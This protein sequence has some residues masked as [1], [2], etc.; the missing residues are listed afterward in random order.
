M[1]EL[2][3]KRLFRRQMQCCAENCT[4][5]KITKCH[6]WN[7]WLFIHVT[8]WQEMSSHFWW[9]DFI[10]I[11][12]V[13]A[14]NR[15]GQSEIALQ[16][17]QGPSISLLAAHPTGM[18]RRCC[19]HLCLG[20]CQNGSLPLSLCPLPSQEGRRLPNALSRLQSA[21]IYSNKL[22]SH[23]LAMPTVIYLFN[24]VLSQLVHQT[25]AIKKQKNTRTFILSQA[26]SC[27]CTV[28]EQRT[29]NQ[30]SQRS[31]YPRD[32]FGVHPN[33]SAPQNAP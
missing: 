8:C 33:L 5:K 16:P 30:H 13:I 9:Y 26:L 21:Y 27:T 11:G 12:E 10:P 22:K 2:V 25:G 19:W 7:L 4:I 1:L 3:R 28:G 14:V 17:L 6:V 29:W 15:V 32:P 23:I 20:S 31:S 24:R 18:T